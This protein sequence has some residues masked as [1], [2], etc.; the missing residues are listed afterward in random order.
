MLFRSQ[1]IDKSGPLHNYA[2]RDHC[3]QYMAA[4]AMIFGTLTAKHYEDEIA[5]DPR[6]DA[7]RAKIVVHEDPR[8][9]ADYA[10][11]RKHSNSNALRVHF[12]DGA[13]TERME[14]EYALG[15]PVRR[16]E[17]MPLLIKKFERNVASAFADPQRDAVIAACLQ[18]S[19][20]EV[21]PISDF[22]DLLAK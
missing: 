8:Y 15:H 9:S 13:S 16:K 18:R 4:T 22:L 6:I 14:V 11:T 10:D 2:D 12:K 19:R 17:A 5:A 1:M 3:L 7:L 20:L 21:T